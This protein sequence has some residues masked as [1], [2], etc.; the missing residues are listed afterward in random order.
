MQWALVDSFGVIVNIIEYDGVSNYT[1][2]GGLT[3]GQVP[4]T[5]RIGDS[6]Y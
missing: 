1:S 6:G 5:A 3:L 4:D 2:E